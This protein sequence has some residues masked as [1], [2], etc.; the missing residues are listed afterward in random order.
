MADENKE[1][2]SFVTEINEE[3]RQENY[4]KLWKSYGKY[5]IA[6]AVLFVFSVAGFQGWKSYS[7]EKKE[8][9]S[10]LFSKA[11][12]DIEG[13]RFNEAS[14]V[15]THLA[16]N[17][18]SGYAT[19]AR[20][21]RAALIAKTG[22][23]KSS[24]EAYL[25]ISNDTT[26]DKTFRD[27]ALLLSAMQELDDGNTNEITTRIELLIKSNNPWRHSAKEILGILMEKEGKNSKAKQ[28]FKELADDVTAPANIR[29]RAAEYL[30]ILGS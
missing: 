2:D 12:K 10:K 9:E 30:M 23:K 11:L 29:A 8:N 15:L 6:G 19:L 20:L 25:F 24:A 21:N 13:E 5:L 14:A 26:V 16:D 3:L 28:L 27:L 1:N 18:T 4:E 22:T 7:T 17:A